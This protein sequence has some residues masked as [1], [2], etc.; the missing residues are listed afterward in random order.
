M[1]QIHNYLSQPTKQSHISVKPVSS[2]DQSFQI[3]LFGHLILD[4]LFMNYD[5]K[6]YASMIMLLILLYILCAQTPSQFQVIL[7]SLIRN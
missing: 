4:W 2:T 6:N 1:K 3:Y 7:I 5:E